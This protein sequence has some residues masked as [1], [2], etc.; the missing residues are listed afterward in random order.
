MMDA[1]DYVVENDQVELA[2]ERIKRLSW[3]NIAD[4][5]AWHND[6][7]RCWRWS[8][9]LYPSIDLLITKLDSKYT[10][11]TVA[12]KRARQLQVKK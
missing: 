10:L 6:I 2:C 5:N 1:Y 8:N 4:V 3:R 7:K 12:A 9:M 11:V